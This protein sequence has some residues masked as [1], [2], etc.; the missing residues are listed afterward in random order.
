MTPDETILCRLELDA[1]GTPPRRAVLEARKTL[2]GFTAWFRDEHLCPDGV[3]LA[4][5]DGAY[6]ARAFGLF[7]KITSSSM[8][9]CR[10]ARSGGGAGRTSTSCARWIDTRRAGPMTPLTGPRR[11]LRRPLSLPS[12]AVEPPGIS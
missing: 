10:K 2:P 9:A 11:A 5:R 1:F 3:E 6:D 4:R 7:S 8:G 12:A